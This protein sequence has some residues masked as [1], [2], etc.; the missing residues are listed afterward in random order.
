MIP[1]V[2]GTI[3]AFFPAFSRSSKKAG[4]VILQPFPLAI[5]SFPLKVRDGVGMGLCGG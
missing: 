5:S 4:G 3:S 2:R 1:F